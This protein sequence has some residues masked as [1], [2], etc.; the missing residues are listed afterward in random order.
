MREWLG[1]SVPLFH[2]G[3][4]RQG[5]GKGLLCDA[6]YRIAEGQTIPHGTYHRDDTALERSVSSSLLGGAPGIL[7]IICRTL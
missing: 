3:A 7:L 4:A 1:D 2:F 5:T 6:L